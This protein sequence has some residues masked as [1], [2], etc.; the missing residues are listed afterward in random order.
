MAVDA[1]PY[2][3][4][5]GGDVAESH[6]HEAAR[7]LKPAGELVILNYSYRGAP[8][9]DRED[10]ERTAEAAGL[11]TILAGTRPFGRWDGTAFRVIKPDL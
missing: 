10:V 1:F 2:L 4:A 7:V 3:V 11:R 6:I 5:A 8:A 9:Q